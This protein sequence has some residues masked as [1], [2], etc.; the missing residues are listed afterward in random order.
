MKILIIGSTG[1][2]G[3][4]LTKTKPIDTEI[5]QCGR[6]ELDLSVPK[7]IN[8]YILGINPDCIIN[9][10]A[11][12]NVDQAEKETDL[13]FKVNAES[14]N[15]IASVATE[16]N[17]KLIHIS[18]D[19]VFDGENNT[20]YKTDEKTNPLG[21]YGKSK[22]KGEL[23]VMKYKN[24]KV[25]RTSWLYGNFGRNF[26]ITM[27]RLHKEK[28]LSN[29]PLFV[30][31]DQI[32]VPTSTYSLAKVCWKLLSTSIDFKNIPPLLH[33]CDAGVC[34]WY[35][36]AIAI[37]EIGFENGLIEKIA[38]VIPIKSNEYQTLAKRPH[39]SLLN[40]DETM[41]YLNIEQPYWR[42]ELTKV[43][44]NIASEKNS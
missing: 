33:W 20:S 35:D 8:N 12:T 38:K 40:C 5:I 18:T 22:A 44:Q 31:A 2:L 28:S 36:F 43:I 13:A 9:S 25:I 7:N 41:K 17:A 24:T 29:D 27:L 6:N 32:G 39:F 14:P 4:T 16:I 34:S 37:G 15:L 3:Q 19:F 21:A 26:C 10:A 42:D 30:V 1:Q 23:L 11:Y